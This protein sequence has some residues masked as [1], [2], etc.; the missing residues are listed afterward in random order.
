MSPKK[1]TAMQLIM[2][3]ASAGV[4]VATSGVWMAGAAVGG[5]AAAGYGLSKLTQGFLSEKVIKKRF[6]KI[7]KE[8]VIDLNKLEETSEKFQRDYD[9]ALR[10][11]ES[12]R[13]W[14]KLAGGAAALVGS[15]AVLEASG[16]M[17]DQAENIRLEKEQVEADTK[18]T[19]AHDK[20]K[21]A[22]KEWLEKP[23]INEIL[24]G[25]LVPEDRVEVVNIIDEQS[26]QETA[27]VDGVKDDT[28]LIKTVSETK[29][30]EIK[31]V[32][33]EANGGQGAISTLRELQANLR[34]EY[35]G[36]EKLPENVDHIINTDAH[37][38]AKE[39]GL[40]RPGEE[41]ESAKVFVGDKLT[42]DKETGEVV[43]SHVKGGE[44]ILQQ[45][46]EYKGDMFDAGKLGAV[47]ENTTG[48]VDP[49]ANSESI[50]GNDEVGS[51]FLKNTPQVDPFANSE[52]IPQDYRV[53]T[54]DQELT[55]NENAEVVTK[56]VSDINKEEA[57]GV[58][59]EELKQ[60]PEINKEE[61]TAD[62]LKQ[63]DQVY[64]RN[65]NS[66]FK[67]DKMDMWDKAKDLKVEKFYGYDIDKMRPEYKELYS[68]IHKI[69]EITGI[70]PIKETLINS[71]ETNLEFI[72]RGLK[73]AALQ[74]KLKDIKL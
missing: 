59:E 67:D 24:K 26:G 18:L 23:E 19:E 8:N 20:L 28:E 57:N 3:T 53:P 44:D 39:Y 62:D 61:L 33:A 17:H 42:F 46:V 36:V 40:Y 27:T 32:E 50:P 48:N 51:E 68:Y 12:T 72:Q 43:F 41:A 56:T 47:S 54:E 58:K 25:E 69:N 35:N 37:E 55:K 15:V 5:A 9:L 11:A 65:I 10:K 7:K 21:Q 52:D 70:E 63:I 66:I 13:I 31:I 45:G 64:E 74:D 49:F 22:E 14:R 71:A 34:D 6:E 60:Q 29:H 1:R 38:L 30:P 73:E 4:A 2:M 16:Y